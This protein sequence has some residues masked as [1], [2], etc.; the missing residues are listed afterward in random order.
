MTFKPNYNQQRADRNRAKTQKKQEKLR[1]L[2]EETAKRKAARGDERGAKKETRELLVK[3]QTMARKLQAGPKD[4]FFS[5]FSMRTAHK[6]RAGR[7]RPP[8]G[9]MVTCSPTFIEAQGR[10]IA[11]VSGRPRGRIKSISRSRKL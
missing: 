11:M 10:E 3:A 2:E 9:S 8:V 1:R 4:S 6:R 5:M 7:F